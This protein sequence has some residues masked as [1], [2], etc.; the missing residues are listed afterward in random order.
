MA[1]EKFKPATPETLQA[2]KEAQRQMDAIH[3][4]AKASVAVYGFQRCKALGCRHTEGCKNRCRYFGACVHDP[5][6]WLGSRIPVSDYFSPKPRKPGDMLGWSKVRL[7]DEDGKHIDV[8]VTRESGT[9]LYL[10]NTAVV[11]KA[12]MKTVPLFPWLPF[13]ERTATNADDPEA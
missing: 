8:R 5:D 11:D 4:A 7:T 13:A 1:A 10:E 12:T 9:R 2:L 3:D 6:A